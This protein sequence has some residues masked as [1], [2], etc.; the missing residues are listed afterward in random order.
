MG[1]RPTTGYANEEIPDSMPLQNRGAIPVL[2]RL[3][4]GELGEHF[5]PAEA[6]RWTETHVMVG[7]YRTDPDTGRRKDRLAWLRAE[8]V[9]RY[10]DPRTLSVADPPRH[11][12]RPHVWAGRIQSSGTSRKRVRVAA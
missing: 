3:V 7:L 4:D 10:C 11:D 1:R 8:D 6:R 5:R 2:V 12:G 9:Y